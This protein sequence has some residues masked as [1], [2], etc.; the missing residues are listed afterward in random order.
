MLKRK[1]CLVCDTEVAPKCRSCPECGYY[2]YKKHKEE[3]YIEVNV[4]R[5][6]FVNSSLIDHEKSFNTEVLQLLISIN[7]KLDEALKIN[8]KKIAFPVEQYLKRIDQKLTLLINE[9]PRKTWVGA[10]VISDLTGWHDHALQKARRNNVIESRMNGN[11]FEYCLESLP[12][13]FI[14]NTILAKK[15]F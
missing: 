10:S 8:D 12:A 14:K 11:R 9:K 6:T 3:E 5:S 4:H 7:K 13:M 2:F 1:K 15:V